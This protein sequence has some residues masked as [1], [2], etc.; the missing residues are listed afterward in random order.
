M[1][2]SWC[3]E[4]L[5]GR[6]AGRGKINNVASLIFANRKC[7][8]ESADVGRL[9]HGRPSRQREKHPKEKTP[10]YKGHCSRSQ[11]GAA[12]FIILKWFITTVTQ[13]AQD[14]K[15][16]LSQVWGT[17]GFLATWGKWD[18]SEETSWTCAEAEETL[19]SEV[20]QI[21]QI[22]FPVGGSGI[23]ASAPDGATKSGN[24]LKLHSSRKQNQATFSEGKP[25]TSCQL[26]QVHNYFDLGSQVGALLHGRTEFP[27]GSG[28]WGSGLD[29]L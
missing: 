9:D 17:E 14:V 19:W 15:R 13:Y 5:G 8:G 12:K 2:R 29:S 21:H 18:K 25:V 7:G 27:A 16:G 4:E 22:Q 20:I 11:S 26:C 1:A 3:V 23:C 28:S 10:L 6:W 24:W